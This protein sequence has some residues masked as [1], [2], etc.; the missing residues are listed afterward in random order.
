MK[1]R[2]IEV[3]VVYTKNMGN[4]ESLKLQGGV[5]F[6][7]KDT[8]DIDIKFKEGWEICERQV[9]TRNEDILARKVKNDEKKR[10]TGGLQRRLKY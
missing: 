6:D 8:D 1:N 2:R 5:S 10:D 3:S 9:K 4:Y 7:I